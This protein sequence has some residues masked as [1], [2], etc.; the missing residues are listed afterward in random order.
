MNKMWIWSIKY[1]DIWKGY[2]REYVRGQNDVEM[3]KEVQY[4]SLIYYDVYF[5]D[6]DILRL[7]NVSQVLL[8]PKPV[9]IDKTKAESNGE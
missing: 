4:G 3:I 5:K 2:P 1:L 8:K 7:F 6:G 9:F